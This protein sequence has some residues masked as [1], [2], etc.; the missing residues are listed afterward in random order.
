MEGVEEPPNS[1]DRADTTDRNAFVVVDGQVKWREGW[2]YDR[3][4]NIAFERAKDGDFDVLMQFTA[5]RP[6]Q[7]SI[8]STFEQRKILT[9]IIAGKLKRRK[10]PRASWAP[11]VSEKNVKFELL[12]AKA[13]RIKSLLKRSYGQTKGINE[14]VAFIMALKGSAHRKILRYLE[15]GPSHRAR[16]VP[17]NK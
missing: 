4:R 5:F 6:Y 9:G 3:W 13:L 10:R 7:V 17:R 1:P 14:R 2:S 15:K 11:Y 12:V 8:D 16:K